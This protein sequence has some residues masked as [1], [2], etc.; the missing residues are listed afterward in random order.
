MPS[1]GLCGMS[2]KG[3]AEGR[4]MERAFVTGVDEAVGPALGHDLVLGPEAQALL[5]VL[6]NV[7]E[8]GALPPAE[9]VVGNRHRD[10]HIDSDHP[11][12]DS[13]SEFARRVAV[14]GED[15]DAVA[16]FVLAG[17]ADCLLEILGADH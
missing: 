9:A 17:E 12:V 1:V 8:T 4:N 5:P 6:A 13:R 11:N 3:S 14:A 7:A 2:S 10:R 16:I 15:R